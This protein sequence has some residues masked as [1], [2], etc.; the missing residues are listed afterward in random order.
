MY[1]HVSKCENDKI[2]ERKKERRK[3]RK[4]KRKKERRK[5]ERNSSIFFSGSVDYIE[6]YIYSFQ[7]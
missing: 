4:R 5:K 2:K 7:L 3:E 1:T 6:K